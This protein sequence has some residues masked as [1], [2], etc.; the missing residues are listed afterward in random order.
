M[1]QIWAHRGAS[2]HAPENTLPA[3]ELAVRQGAQGVELDVQRTADGTL[4]VIHDETVDR[5]SDGMGRVVD[6]TLAQL[7]SLDLRPAK[8]PSP[9]A[10]PGKEP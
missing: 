8:D 1:T 6:L 9:G 7:R 2:A 10:K 4:V 3:F 5:V